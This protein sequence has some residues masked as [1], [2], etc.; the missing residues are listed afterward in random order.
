MIRAYSRAMKGRCRI[1][2]LV[3]AFHLTR[4]HHDMGT[5]YAGYSSTKDGS[6]AH[7]ADDMG[8]FLDLDVVL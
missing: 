8:L 4:T 7:V 5:E 6:R 3:S 2:W 1:S